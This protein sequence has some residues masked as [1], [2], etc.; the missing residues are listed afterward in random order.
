L[1]VATMIVERVD[2]AVDAWHRS[3]SDA[4]LAD[5]LGMNLE[6]YAAW[7]QL[8]VLPDGYEPPVEARQPLAN[9]PVR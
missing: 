2:E 6:Q 8:G 4:P 7:V 9:S 3:D 5:W 1:M